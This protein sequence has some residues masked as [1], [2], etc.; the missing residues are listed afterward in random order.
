MQMLS[1]WQR[2]LILIEDNEDKAQNL[3]DELGNLILID[4]VPI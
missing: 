3:L 1:T 2:P 4:M